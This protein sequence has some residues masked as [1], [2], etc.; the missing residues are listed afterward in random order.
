MKKR[1][2]FII[3]VFA[4]IGTIIGSGFLG[5]P[6]VIGKS[7]FSLG[8]LNLALIALIMVI[9]MLY[10]GEITLR[11]NAT[12]QLPG[13]AE[14]YLGKF[15]KKAMFLA[16]S[17]GVYAALV[18]Y[19]IA[20]GESISYILFGTTQYKIY[21]SFLFWIVMSLISY[22]GL[23][24]MKK[25]GPW[26]ITLMFVMT[27]TIS[28]LLFNKVDSQNFEYYNIKEFLTPF[29]VIIFAF[30]GFTAIPEMRR[31]LH[32]E[33]FLLKSSII[34]A[35][36]ISFTIYSLFVFFVLGSQGKNTPE[37][38]TIALG[39]PFIILAMVTMFNA[40]LAHSVAMADIFVFDFNKKRKLAWLYTVSIPIIMLILLSV[41]NKASFTTVMSIGGVISG[42]FT[43]TLIF[44]MVKKAKLQGDRKP[45]YSIGYSEALIRFLI[46]IFAIATIFQIKSLIS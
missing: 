39:V 36:A 27:I 32:A 14:K 2:N 24:A 37:I 40:Y 9:A 4:L 26:G 30:L 13:Y 22:S 34:T 28:I 12:H 20:E 16:T 17:F 45:E 23:K 46:I 41:F 33:K 25:G 21:M 15:G 7:G 11:T 8:M 31:I 1:S 19:L 6:Y 38:A 18:A 35:Y 5:L 44:L 43:A 10:L 42:G 29:G 3:A